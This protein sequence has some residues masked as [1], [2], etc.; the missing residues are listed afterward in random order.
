MQI[1]IDIEKLISRSIIDGILK[2]DIIQ[3]DV[4]NILE[5]G[6]YQKILDEHIKARFNELLFS[7]DGKKQIDK[8]IIDGIV[9]SDKIQ[10]NT[11]E[12]LEGDE[13]QEILRQHTKDCLHEVIFSEEGKRQIFSKVKEYLESYDIEYDDSFSNELTKG[14]SDILL[15]MMRDSFKRLKTVNKQ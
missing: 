12:I 9:N 13:Y 3:E 4:N 15:T 5:S 8:G 7:E 6:E 11:E 10:N 14:I 2:N 1:E